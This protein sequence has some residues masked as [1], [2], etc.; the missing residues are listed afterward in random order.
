MAEW[1]GSSAEASSPPQKAKPPSD[2]KIRALIGPAW[3]CYQN[4]LRG[5][6]ALGLKPEFYPY[7]PSGGWALRFQ[8]DHATGCALYL[9][10]SLTGLVA[11]GPR[12]EAILMRDEKRDPV[13]ARL[14]AAT[15]RRGKVRWVKMPLRSQADVRRFL[16]LVETK[17]QGRQ[18]RKEKK[19]DEKKTVSHTPRRRTTA[20]AKDQKKSGTRPRRSAARRSS[21]G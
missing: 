1:M 5:L 13:V 21:R 10:H 15:P 7:D 19:E 8:V 3:N 4:A 18:A 16:Y 14:V 2:A 12:A 17:L 20:A 11:V 6:G 9:A